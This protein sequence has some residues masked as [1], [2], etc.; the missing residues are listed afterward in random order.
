MEKQVEIGN[1]LLAIPLTETTFGIVSDIE[2]RQPGIS[3]PTVLAKFTCSAKAGNVTI[4]SYATKAAK[5]KG[6]L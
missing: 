4:R 1:G 3:R 5:A 2:A 6:L